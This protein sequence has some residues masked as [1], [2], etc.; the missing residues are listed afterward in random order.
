VIGGSTQLDAVAFRGVKRYVIGIGENYVRKRIASLMESKGLISVQIIHPSAIVA[1]NV[2]LDCG[3]VVMA[4]AVINVGTTV[5]A[6][7]IVNTGCRIDHDCSVGDFAH[8]SPG[9]T[10]GGAVEVGDLVHLG[11]GAIVLPGCKIGEGSVVG[12]GAVVVEDIPAGVIARG[13]PARVAGPVL[14]GDCQ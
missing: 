7:A 2:S 4:G 9:A 13:I 5:G 11:L 8:V 3:T 1:R 12:A 10:I 14:K 6:H